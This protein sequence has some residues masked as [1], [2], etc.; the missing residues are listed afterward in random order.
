M[1]SER[2][3]RTAGV[4]RSPFPIAPVCAIGIHAKG[5]TRDFSNDSGLEQQWTSVRSAVTDTAGKTLIESMDMVSTGKNTAALKLLNDF[6][7]Q[8]SK[9]NQV[10]Y[11]LGKVALNDGDLANAETIFRRLTR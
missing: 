10:L 11:L 5:Y 2:F 6:L 1:L 7:A 8:T 4:L 3:R 9:D